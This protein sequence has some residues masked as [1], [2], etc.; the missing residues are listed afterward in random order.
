MI[1]KS[2][3]YCDVLNLACDHDPKQDFIMTFRIINTDIKL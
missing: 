2:S 1:N 3:N